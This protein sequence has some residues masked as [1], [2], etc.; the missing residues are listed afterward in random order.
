MQAFKYPILK[1]TLFLIIGIILREYTTIAVTILLGA[2]GFMLVVLVFIHYHCKKYKKTLYWPSLVVVLVMILLGVFVSKILHVTFS[3]SHYT[4]LETLRDSQVHQ[5]EFVIKK[6]LKPTTYNQR[7]YVQVL[8]IDSTAVSGTLLINLSKKSTP[9]NF[10]VNAK[11]FTMAVLEKINPPQNP[12]QFNYKNYLKR[13]GI[14]HQITLK[15]QIVEV[16]PQ[17]PKTLTGYAE[18]V[19]ETLNKRLQ[20]LAFNPIELAFVKALFL[21]QRQD[22]ASDVYADYAKA[23]VVHILAISGLHIGIILMILLFILQPLLYFKR[24]KTIRLLFILVTLWSFAV[25][26]GLS[27][28]V[29][30]AVTMF[31]LFAIVKG[32]KRSSNSINTLAI[33]AFVLLLIRPAFCFDLGFQLSYAAVA[34][35]IIIKPILDSWIT[36]KNGI[37]NWFLDLLKLSVAA[38]LGVLPLSLYYFHQFPGLFFVTNLV[39][40]P[41]LMLVLGLGIVMFICLTLYQPPEFIIQVLGWLIQFMNRFVDW[42]ATKEAFLFDEISFDTTALVFSYFTLFVLGQFYLKKSYKHLMFL[43]I[44]ILSFQIVAKLIPLLHAKNSFIVFHKSRHSVFGFRTNQHLEIHHDLESLKTQ[45][46]LKD[47][48]IGAAIKTQSTDSIRGLYKIDD[49]LLLVVDSLGIYNINSVKPQWVLLR[50]SPKINLNR[51][52]DSLHPKLIIWDGSNYKTFQERWKKT[53][54]TQNI[55][56][57]QTSENGAF[58]VDY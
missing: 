56:Y 1:L 16:F 24:G 2:I 27:P 11:V 36:F 6:R 55:R 50:Q 35:I 26:A 40:V 10:N 47:Y 51:M 8:R 25:I 15:N 31:S 46:I 39:I 29:V 44:C 18:L 17:P 14:H 3:K 41:C 42:I 52:I 5:L 45:R 37:T 38:Q 54:E 4:H 53:C 22:I 20:K 43:G 7:Y 21:G 34:A 48:K 13:L 32:L 28:S 58:W 49:K 9:K 30:R 23:G 57:H 12:Y 33:S 19:R